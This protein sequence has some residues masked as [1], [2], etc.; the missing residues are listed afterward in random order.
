[1][2]W[3]EKLASMFRNRDL[4]KRMV[5]GIISANAPELGGALGAWY[6]FKDKPYAQDVAFY[7]LT[8]TALVSS[9]VGVI[10]PLLTSA[11]TKAG[12]GGNGNGGNGG[13]NNNNNK[14]KNKGK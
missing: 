3:K 10:M 5:A 6:T 8:N 7:Q 1:M 9:A 13:R 2:G 12:S 11:W 14:K 4:G